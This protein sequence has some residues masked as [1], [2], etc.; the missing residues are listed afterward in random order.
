MVSY[1][2]TILSPHEYLDAIVSNFNQP[3][4][5]GIILPE[6]GMKERVKL[7]LR[8]EFLLLY[9]KNYEFW[10]HEHNKL[11]DYHTFDLKVEIQPHEGLGVTIVG[12]QPVRVSRVFINSPADYYG[13]QPDDLIGSINRIDVSQAKHD[14]VADLLNSLSGVILFKIIRTE[15]NN[16]IFAPDKNIESRTLTLTNLSGWVPYSRIPL[17]H[18]SI[19]LYKSGTAI[20][21]KNG[22]SICSSDGNLNAT[23]HYGNQENAEISTWVVAIRQAIQLETL[24]FIHNL[25]SNSESILIMGWLFERLISS[26]NYSFWVR[27][28]LVCTEYDV[29]IYSKPPSDGHS[30]EQFEA[31]YKLQTTSYH[32]LQD[33]NSLRSNSFLLRSELGTHHIFSAETWDYLMMWLNAFN[34]SLYRIVNYSPS[35]KYEGVWKKNK[36]FFVLNIAQSRIQLLDVTGISLIHS[37]AFSAIKSTQEFANNIV[38]NFENSLY[39]QDI[40]SIQMQ[41]EHV[42][43]VTNSIHFAL[44]AKVSENL[45]EF[46]HTFTLRTV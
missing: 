17:L 21:L 18:A 45:P 9:H 2:T 19:T 41:F 43:A 8:G 5:I 7:L 3:K 24:S 46:F 16:L 31:S 32:L 29:L 1:S 30:W 11:I 35:I 14:I 20:R 6:K 23:I 12:E 37:W 40:T 22:F 42:S 26:T 13:I 10:E 39:S 15:I 33:K 34:S 4:T 27:K 36:I 38:L 28:F 25:R 44:L